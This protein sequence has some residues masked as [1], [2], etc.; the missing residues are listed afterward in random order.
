MQ[1]YAQPLRI[2]H[3]TELED[4]VHNKKRITLDAIG[5]EASPEVVEIYI[6]GFFR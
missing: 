3:I 6:K 4:F 1:A 2:E 5:R